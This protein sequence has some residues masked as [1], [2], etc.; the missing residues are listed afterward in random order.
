[1]VTWWEEQGSRLPSLSAVAW[2]RAGMIDK[3]DEGCKQ[4][5]TKAE[6]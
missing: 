5:F 3:D 4:L 6:K 2:R 1:M